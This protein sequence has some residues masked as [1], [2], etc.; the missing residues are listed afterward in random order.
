VK[1]NILA[2]RNLFGTILII[3]TIDEYKYPLGDVMD[4]LKEIEN[5]MLLRNL[6]YEIFYLRKTFSTMDFAREALEFGKYFR[7]VIVAEEQVRGRGR[8]GRKWV[9]PMGGLWTT[10]TTPTPR[11]K[12]ELTSIIAGLAVTVSLKEL[13]GLNVQL[14]WPNDIVYLGFKLGGILVENLVYGN[15]IISLVGI[16]I[17]CNNS[18][19]DLGIE[20]TISL[21]EI[22][23]RR[24]SR[25]EILEKIVVNLERFFKEYT[26]FEIIETYKR[27]CFSLGRK[28]KI[29]VNEEIVEG[30]VCD[31]TNKGGLIVRTSGKDKVIVNHGDVIE[32]EGVKYKLG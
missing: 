17:N 13:Y 6:G 11:D 16:G 26:T 7:A 31:I 28:V 23:G 9:S 14:K 32:H 12:L 19:L 29:K 4:N 1:T 5:S 2:S 3:S 21:R 25:E 22:L 30:I 20:G 24:V 27:Y 18:S 8:K 15:E 10:I